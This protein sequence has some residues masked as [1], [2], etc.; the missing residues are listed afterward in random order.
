[1]FARLRPVDDRESQKTRGYYLH[2]GILDSA[3]QATAGLLMARMEGAHGEESFPTMVPIGIE[4][5]CIYKFVQ[6]GEY[7]SHVT[8]DESSSNDVSSDL[9]HCNIDLYD[10]NG[11]PC[12]RIA[13]LQLKRIPSVVRAQTEPAKPHT[14][15]VAEQHA[16]A[17]FFHTA[18]TAR[19]AMPAVMPDS[20]A[21][22]LLLG[23]RDAAEQVFASTL[24]DA[25][26][27]VVLAPYAH[28]WN[29]DAA[30]MQSILEQAGAVNGIVFLG[31]YATS[32]TDGDAADVGTMRVLFTLF[33]AMTAHSRKNKD[34]Q[35]IRF[36]RA[37]QHA[38]RTGDTAAGFDIR[39]SL[40]TGFLRSA[41]LEFPLMDVR[42]VDLGH[43]DPTQLGRCLYQELICDGSGATGGPEALY[44]NQQRHSLE[45]IP[46][47]V[48]R[49]HERDIVFNAG[50]TFWIIGGVSGVGQVLARYLA[51]NFKCNLVLS[52]T[53]QL[54]P[55]E[56]HDSY[57]AGNQNAIASTIEFIREIESLGSTVT[58]IST[59]VR[60]ADSM[61]TSLDTIRTAYP[62]L[63]GIYFSALQL[64]DKMIL[65]KEWPGYQNMIDM[66]VNGLHELI[67]QTQPDQ[68]DF[69]VLFSSLAGITGNIGQ[70][71]Y[72]ASNVYMDS[73][74]Y[75]Q[76]SD[77]RCRYITVQWGVWELGQKA[78][79]I[80]LEQLRRLGFLHVSAQSGMAALENLILS[81]EKNAAFVPGTY[82]AEIIADNLNGLRQGLKTKPK[83]NSTVQA[84]QIEEHVMSTT[85][86]KADTTLS[87]SQIQL[88]MNEFEKQREM[89]MR[90][91]ENQNSLLSNTLSGLGIDAAPQSFTSRPA[92]T[93][94]QAAAPIAIPAPE[95]VYSMPA[96]ALPIAATFQPSVAAPPS[97]A[98]PAADVAPQA[99]GPGE[100]PAS[101]ERP[102]SL[103]DYVRSLMAKAVEMHETD[104]DPDQNIM[105]LGA[106]S[107]TAMSMVKELETR[108]KIELPATLLF[109]YSTLNELVDFLKT[110]IV[111]SPSNQGA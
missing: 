28:Y 99:P 88:L 66:R 42:Q 8:L 93:L 68:L 107:M 85:N 95:P 18:W 57:L 51:S 89:L 96:A 102:T 26:V 103:F 71:D 6:N 83:V 45:V 67:R 9:I 22:W 73:V 39:K 76:P 7:F 11:V 77:N 63:D 108:Y 60:S 92:P 16:A 1:V 110:E 69:F 94:V 35:R 4:S 19:P 106:D 54:P 24:A 31:D 53:R 65:Q 44:I 62:R 72:S 70:T 14:P 40:A 13:K 21:R 46:L 30:A 27:D 29:A 32:V 34:Y 98:A 41:R 86:I 50:K 55:P 38:Y 25:G 111:D 74:P 97:P 47:S 56:Q 23:S 48:N 84:K 87:D 101:T 52:G 37:T 5:I 90:L 3:F 36:I 105:E 75:A 15:P 43:G 17:A 78:A 10:N 59:D 100:P 82:H 61:R 12:A 64:D 49:V 2:P 58:Y 79:E 33:K 91:V 20:D 109:E 80:V 104:I 81:G